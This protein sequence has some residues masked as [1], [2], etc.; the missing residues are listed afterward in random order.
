LYLTNCKKLDIY[1][2]EQRKS[3]S[4]IEDETSSGISRGS[5]IAEMDCRFR[6]HFK[7]LGNS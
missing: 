3:N 7:D 4:N 1:V 2:V 5:D 6:R